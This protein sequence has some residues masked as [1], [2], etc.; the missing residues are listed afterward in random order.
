MKIIPHRGIWS[1]EE[2]KNSLSSII[3]ALDIFDGVEI[4]LRDYKSE[5]VIGHDPF[6]GGL[7][8]ETFLSKLSSDQKK[9]FFALNI[10]SDGLSGRLEELIS[11]YEIRNFMCFDMSFPETLQYKQK[12]LNVF[13]R[14]SDLEKGISKKQT[15]RVVDCFRTELEVNKFLHLNEE[16]FVISPELHKRDPYS[17]WVKLRENYKARSENLMICT[18]FPFILQ[19]VWS[20]HD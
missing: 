12:K 18:D 2:D 13:S 9:K 11:R 8:F 20:S 1:V 14:M 19:D 7:S 4:D 3:D 15:G 16:L 10:K 6:V 5:I 17:Y